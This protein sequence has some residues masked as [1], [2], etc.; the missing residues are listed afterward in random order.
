MISIKAKGQLV[1]ATFCSIYWIYYLRVD[2]W[3]KWRSFLFTPFFI[4]IGG[5]ILYGHVID[6]VRQ[7][8]HR[9]Y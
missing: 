1:F 8:V 9:P 4:S 2:S 3:K 5:F 7:G 6:H